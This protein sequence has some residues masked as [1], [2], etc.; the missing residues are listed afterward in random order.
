MLALKNK[1]RTFQLRA[2][3]D[4]K[5]KEHISNGIYPVGDQRRLSKSLYSSWLWGPGKIFF[6]N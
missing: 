5:R 3:K 6:L 1:R 4:Q 2:P